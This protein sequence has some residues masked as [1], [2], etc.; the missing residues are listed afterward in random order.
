MQQCRRHNHAPTYDRLTQT[1]R[2][3]NRWSWI[4]S[5]LEF[6]KRVSEKSLNESYNSAAVVERWGVVAPPMNL[7]SNVTGGLD[8][9]VTI[10]DAPSCVLLDGIFS[11]S[12]W[13]SAT[14]YTRCT[15]YTIRCALTRHN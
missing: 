14:R 4:F 2:R 15:R 9:N 3:A 1:G 10:V 6:P 11:Y 5:T 7:S 8:I 13:Q 12:R